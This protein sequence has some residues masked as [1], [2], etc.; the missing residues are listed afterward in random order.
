MRAGIHPMR[1]ALL[2]PVVSP[3]APPFLGGAQ[4]LLRDLAAGLARRG[5]DVALYAADGSH[6]EGVRTVPLGIDAERLRHAQA[7]FMSTGDEDTAAPDLETLDDTLDPLQ[8]YGEVLSPAYAF[9]HAYR[10]LARHAR[11]H[12]LVHAHA[13]D[14]PAYAYS[15][16]QP[17]PII[18]TLHL[19]ALDPRINSV[20]ALLAPLDGSPARARLTTVSHACAATYAS[21]CRMDAVIYNGVDI[22]AIPFGARPAEPPYLLFAGRISPEKGVL[23]ALT[24]ARRAGLRLLLAGDVYDEGYF[25]DQV[26]PVVAAAGDAAEYLGPVRRERLHE[27]MAGAMAVLCPAQWD[28]PFGLV[29][30]EAHAAGA[31]VIAYARG[32]LREVVEDGVSGWLVPPGDVAAAVV[33]V[34]RVAQLGR[35]ACRD[36]AMRRFSLDTMLDA[37]EAFYEETL[38]RRPAHV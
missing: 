19:P 27:L 26:A 13:Y 30:C 29:A 38:A 20:L 9:L 22:G 7:R 32:G 4:V 25:R 17:L 18:H 31:P 23:D 34:A 6:I 5:H 37:Y 3:I 12:D 1:I 10:T 15:S 35:A 33:G 8:G 11:A 14:W 21:V 28:E 16:L 36:R 2:A 24:I